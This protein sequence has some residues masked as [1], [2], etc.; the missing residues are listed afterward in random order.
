V[1]RPKSDRFN[2]IEVRI[3]YVPMPSQDKEKRMKDSRISARKLPSVPEQREHMD[4]FWFLLMVIIG[5]I[6]LIALSIHKALKPL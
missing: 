6:A 3:K 5:F 4:S 1:E 2:E